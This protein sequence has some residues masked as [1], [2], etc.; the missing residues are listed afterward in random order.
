MAQDCLSHLMVSTI[1][2]LSKTTN[3]RYVPAGGQEA[4]I[5]DET[6]KKL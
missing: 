2:A 5:M 4:T 6:V 1:K 3:L